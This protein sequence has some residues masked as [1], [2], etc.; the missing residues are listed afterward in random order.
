MD[1]DHKLVLNPRENAA[2]VKYVYNKAGNPTDTLKFNTAMEEIKKNAGA[3]KP[4]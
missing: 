3:A 1:K 4:M 2:V